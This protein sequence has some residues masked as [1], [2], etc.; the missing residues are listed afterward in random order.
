MAPLLGNFL[1]RRLYESGVVSPE[2]LE[3][4]RL[5]VAGSIPVRP[6]TADGAIG[7][8][9]AARAEAS[10]RAKARKAAAALLPPRSKGGSS[11]KFGEPAPEVKVLAALAVGGAI[12]GGAARVRLT[13]RVFK[14][15]RPRKR[16]KAASELC[17][18]CVRVGRER[19]DG[20]GGEV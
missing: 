20:R 7:S 12:G 11:G 1:K 6:L 19:R 17:M 5:G 15:A 4:E 13:L 2:E 8:A 16:K 18:V 10:A 14:V 9:G 3:A